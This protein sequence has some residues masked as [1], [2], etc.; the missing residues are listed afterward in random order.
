MY[1]LQMEIN[2][3]RTKVMILSAVPALATAVPFTCNG[4][5]VQQVATLELH[6]HHDQS[7]SIAHLVMPIKLRTGGSWAAV[8]HGPLGL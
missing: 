8:L 6:F 7:G 3:P 2:V 1:L 4:N 5:S